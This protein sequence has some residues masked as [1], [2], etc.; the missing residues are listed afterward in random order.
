MARIKPGK[1]LNQWSSERRAPGQLG[2]RDYALNTKKQRSRR[3]EVRQFLISNFEIR[4]SKCGL[5]AL[6]A[7][8]FAL[9]AYIT[10]GAA[11]S[12]ALSSP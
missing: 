6:C 7:M 8:R 11:T 10:M 4:I 5:Y 3:S 1:W 9:C 12:L 2:T